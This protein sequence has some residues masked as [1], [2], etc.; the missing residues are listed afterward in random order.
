MKKKIK[1]LCVVLLFFAIFLFY[2]KYNFNIDNNEK[3]ISNNQFILENREYFLWKKTI[4]KILQDPL[5]EERDV[6]D[7]GHFLMIPLYSA[8]ISEDQSRIDD[9]HHFFN[10]FVKNYNQEEFNSLGILNKLHFLYLISEYLVLTKMHKEIPSEELSSI[11]AYQL[12]IIWNQ[13][14]WHWVECDS[15]VFEN[16]Q[17]RINWKLNNK[18]VSVSYCRAIIDEEL[19]TLAIAGDMKF[20]L[21]DYSPKFIDNALGL[22]YKIFKQEV[23]FLNNTTNEWLFQ[24][25]VWQEHRDYNYSGW[26]EVKPNLTKN[27]VDEIAWDTSHFHRFPLWLVSLQRGFISQEELN[28]AEYFQKLRQGLAVQFL[29]KVLVYPSEEFPNY[30]TTNF[31]DGYNGIY[32]YNHSSTQGLNKG[33][34]KY[35]LSGTM[36][37]GWWSFLPDK[38]MQEKYC[39]IA[40]R[41]PLS[42]KEIDIYLG[43]DTVRNRHPLIKGKA[44]F[45]S[46]LLELI[47]IL[48]CKLD[49]Q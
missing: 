30:R 24:I 48:A 26:N 37:I 20:I 6:Y 3:N 13:Q 2:F 28:K 40:S 34:D 14:A 43:H 11:V 16:M 44:Q 32:R 4:K 42:Q 18:K 33:Y 5:W 8:F 39:F 49:A 17:E 15:P 19:F 21:S 22:S 35:E 36:L 12:E 1:I 29:N 7:A 25:G 9:F 27:L 46:G 47:S 41:F 38:I 31:M 23:I 10:R 45:E